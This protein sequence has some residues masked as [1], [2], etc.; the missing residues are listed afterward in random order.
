LVVSIAMDDFVRCRKRPDGIWLVIGASQQCDQ[1]AQTHNPRPGLKNCSERDP[2]LT[3]PEGTI[4]RRATRVPLLGGVRMGVVATTKWLTIV[5]IP[6]NQA[7]PFGSTSP[8]NQEVHAAAR[9]VRRAHLVV[10]PLAFHLSQVGLHAEPGDSGTA[11]GGPP[12][13]LKRS[14]SDAGRPARSNAC[15]GG[16]LSGAAAATLVRSRASMSK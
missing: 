2:P 9:R 15:N 4:R 16:D 11:T 3:P 8:V 7:G 5:S 12:V 1:R 13:I 10:D 6:T 14:R